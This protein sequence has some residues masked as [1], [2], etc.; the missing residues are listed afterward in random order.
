MKQMVVPIHTPFPSE[1]PLRDGTENHSPAMLKHR[2]SLIDCLTRSNEHLRV[3]GDGLVD[4][5]MLFWRFFGVQQ[6]GRQPQQNQN[7]QQEL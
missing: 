2:P 3:G 4:S 7:L 5:E 1:Y 6:K